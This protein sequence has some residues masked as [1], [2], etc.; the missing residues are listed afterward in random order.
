[1]KRENIHRRRLQRVPP[2]PFFLAWPLQS[3]LLGSPWRRLENGCE[4]QKQLTQKAWKTTMPQDRDWLVILRP[5]GKL[6]WSWGRSLQKWA[7]YKSECHYGVLV[8]NSALGGR[9]GGSGCYLDASWREVGLSWAILA[10]SWE[11]HVGTKMAK[12]SQDRRTWVNNGWLWA[13]TD[14][15]GR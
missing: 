8:K 15:E 12:M 3:A 1:M 2:A 4:N 13:M 9:V 7:T 14:A 11:Q 10:S 6:S 5:V